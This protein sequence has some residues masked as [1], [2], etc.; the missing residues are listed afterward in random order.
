MIRMSVEYPACNQMVDCV[1]SVRFTPALKGGILSSKKDSRTFDGLLDELD[2]EFFVLL[3]V[4]DLRLIREHIQ[5]VCSQVNFDRV[6][7]LKRSRAEAV[8][9]LEEDVLPPNGQ[10]PLRLVS[11]SF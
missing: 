9:M 8:Q 2:P 3:R 4:D 10:Q 7:P 6:F 1:G 11:H 5:L